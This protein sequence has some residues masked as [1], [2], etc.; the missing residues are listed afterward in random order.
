MT[1]A[2]LFAAGR[3]WSAQNGEEQIGTLPL[4]SNGRARA[5]NTLRV[6][7]NKY[8]RVSPWLGSHECLFVKAI[9]M[10]FGR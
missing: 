1:T 8:L 3:K 4:F 2:A 9:A 7:R 10:N 5:S 6:R